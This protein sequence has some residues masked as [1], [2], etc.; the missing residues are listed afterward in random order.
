MVTSPGRVFVREAGHGLTWQRDRLARG[1][2]RRR[3][4]RRHPKSAVQTRASHPLP[5]LLG[6]DHA[7]RCESDLSLTRRMRTAAPY[8]ELSAPSQGGD[9][10]SNPVGGANERP[11]QTPSASAG[12][13]FSCPACQPA[14]HPLV[15]SR[16]LALRWRASDSS[17]P[18]GGSFGS[19][20]AATPSMGPRARS[21]SSLPP[22]AAASPV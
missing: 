14:C 20:P 10:G 12:G 13:F 2:P 5:R 18:A 21:A 4:G 11:S 8:A 7:A 19:T 6:A 15:A 9:T 17:P 22:S 16:G 3:G 1:L